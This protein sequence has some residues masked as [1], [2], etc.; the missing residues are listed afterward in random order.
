LSQTTAIT[1]ITAVFRHGSRGA[2]MNSS[3]FNNLWTGRQF[4][5]SNPPS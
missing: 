3:A 4:S 5:F 2:I 1:G